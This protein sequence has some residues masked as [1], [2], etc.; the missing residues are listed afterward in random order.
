MLD[1][2]QN[3]LCVRSSGRITKVP[4]SSTSS[5][6]PEI[7]TDG[8]SPSTLISRLHRSRVCSPPLDDVLRAPRSPFCRYVR[9]STDCSFLFRLLFAVSR[10][11]LSFAHTPIGCYELV[12]ST[13]FHRSLL[14]PVEVFGI[15]DLRLEARKG[16]IRAM[17]VRGC[18]GSVDE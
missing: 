10:S 1:A 2:A 12:W 8:S 13:R 17:W 18:G 9:S 3:D 16:C 15:L 14:E 11:C 6:L 7:L 5:R 4:S